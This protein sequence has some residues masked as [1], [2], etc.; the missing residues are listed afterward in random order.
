MAESQPASLDTTERYRSSSLW[1]EALRNLLH[2]PSA[3]LGMGII[4]L[5]LLTA[6]AAPLIATHNPIKTMIGVP[7]ETGR[8]AQQTSLY[9]SIWL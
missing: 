6:V 7:G 8:V 3:I 5:L 1:L 4:G 9:S 2:N